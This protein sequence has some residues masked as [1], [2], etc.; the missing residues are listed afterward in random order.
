MLII[1]LRYLFFF[2]T[3]NA[4]IHFIKFKKINT[5]LFRGIPFLKL[6]EAILCK[7]ILINETILVDFVPAENNSIIDIVLGK[8]NNG[9]MRVFLLNNNLFYY[10]TQIYYMLENIPMQLL[11]TNDDFHLLQS[12]HLMYFIFYLKETYKNKKYNLYNYN[13]KHFCKNILSSS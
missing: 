7:S 12:K 9:K 11:I 10:D 6:H 4:F 2:I 8:T 13:C 1:L 5:N 3:I